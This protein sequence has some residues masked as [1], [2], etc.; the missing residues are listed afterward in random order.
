MAIKCPGRTSKRAQPKLVLVGGAKPKMRK[1]SRRDWT[2]AKED[3]YV[4]VL[5]ETCNLTAAAVAAKV[6][7]NSA[8]ERRK[9]N[10]RFRASCAEAIGCAYEQL[11]LAILDRSLNGSEK[12]IIRKDGSEERIREYPTAVALTLLRMHRQTAAEAA[13][14]PEGVDID[15]VRQRLFAKL[16]RLRKRDD[17]EKT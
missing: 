15:E 6:S 16:Q 10:A 8:R 17:Q 13:S 11:E 4:N 1:A 14:E 5:A 7:V 9:T 2:K 3:T 12:I